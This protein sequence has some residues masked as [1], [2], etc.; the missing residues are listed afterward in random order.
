[1]AKQRRLRDERDTFDLPSD[2]LGLPPGTIVHVGERRTE[3]VELELIR[4][5]AKEIE[6]LALKPDGPFD[7]LKDRHKISWLDLTGVHDVEAVKRIG[8]FFGLHHLVLEDVANTHQ[9]PKEETYKDYLFIVLKMV[10]YD[11]MEEGLDT[12]QV[13]LVLGADYIIS[14]QER[15]GDVFDAVRKRLDAGRGR[16]RLS[17]AD[18]LCYALVD[19]IVDHYFLALEKLSEEIEFIEDEILL[20]PGPE[21][22]EKL[23]RLRRYAVALRRAAWPLRETVQ[24][25]SREDST[26]IS[27]DTKPYLMDLYDHVVQVV[28]T[29]EI[30]RETLSG[31]VELYLS[32]ISQRMNEVMK[33]LTIVATIFIPLTFVA[34][35]Y[36]MNFEYMP[37]LKWK[38]GYAGAWA[39]MFAIGLGMYLFFRR[40]K[41]L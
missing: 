34:G 5:D 30:Q 13:S 38:W 2:K 1:M 8:D 21:T 25:L 14:F 18:Y 24:K 6:K 20:D 16:I 12:E 40:K 10:R 36:G 11:G 37:E 15:P 33:V 32:S 19:I 26:L 7:E 41:W 28:D 4:Y 17:G 3:A 35:I 27:D 23:H 39:G 31:Y 9:R 22:I 29:I